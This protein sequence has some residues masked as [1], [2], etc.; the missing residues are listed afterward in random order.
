M[1]TNYE[2]RRAL[3]RVITTQDTIKE[4]NSRI[5]NVILGE[6][7]DVLVRAWSHVSDMGVSVS[8][9]KN[10]KSLVKKRL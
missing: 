3:A 9:F 8:E 2:F 7:D 1:R 5:A 6:L 10:I 4:S